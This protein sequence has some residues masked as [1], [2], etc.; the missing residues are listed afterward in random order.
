MLA[1]FVT[2]IIG[3][4]AVI[5]L[6]PP[7]NTES[8]SPHHPPCHLRPCASICSSVSLQFCGEHH[9]LFFIL[10]VIIGLLVKRYNSYTCFVTNELREWILELAWALVSIKSSLCFRVGKNWSLGKFLDLPWVS[11]PVCRRAETG[12]SLWPSGLSI[13]KTFL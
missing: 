4:D 6:C 7:R 10:P 2:Q 9:T 8:H 1:F 11:W 5:Y 13:F 3:Q 12:C